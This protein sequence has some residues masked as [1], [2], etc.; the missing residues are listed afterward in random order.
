MNRLER[1]MRLQ[2]K[3]ETGIA[4]LVIAVSIVV[5]L[6]MAALGAGWIK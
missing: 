2:A 5:I 1:K 4:V 6:L 3:I